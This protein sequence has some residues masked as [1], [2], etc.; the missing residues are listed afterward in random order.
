M[1]PEVRLSWHEWPGAHS[2]QLDSQLVESLSRRHVVLL[3][4][5][6]WNRLADGREE[7]ASAIKSK[8]LRLNDAERNFCTLAAPN[9]WELRKQAGPSLYLKAE[10]M[11][12]LSDNVVYRPVDQLASYDGVAVLAYPF[13]NPIKP[14]RIKQNVPPFIRH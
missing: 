14:L 13:G 4:T 8:L 7:G 11:E 9:I 2:F 12:G 6:V 3:D 5:S 10:L 1:R